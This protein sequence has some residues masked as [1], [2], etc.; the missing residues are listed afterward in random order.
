MSK[1]VVYFTATV[2]SPFEVEAED[3]ASAIEAA[4]ERFP[5]PSICAQCSGWGKDYGIDLGDWEVADENL[6]VEELS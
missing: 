2:S 4:Y 6:D 5:N 3:K 1:F